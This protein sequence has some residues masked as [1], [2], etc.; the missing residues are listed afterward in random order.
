MNRVL[1]LTISLILISCAKSNTPDAADPNGPRDALSWQ[2]SEPWWA[3]NLVPHAGTETITWV[4]GDNQGCQS[5]A[6]LDGAGN[7]T[8]SGSVEIS[9]AQSGEA[10][11]SMFDGN[12]T[13]S[14]SNGLLTLCQAAQ[15]C[16]VF[17]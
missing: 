11:C 8:I 12:W 10:P 13:Y 4:I 14:I 9:Q 3:T 5:T 17:Y 16:V 7:M 15:P 1:L 6:V 2:A